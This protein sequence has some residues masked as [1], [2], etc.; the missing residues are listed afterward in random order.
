MPIF[1]TPITTDDNNIHKLVAQNIPLLIVFYDNEID[2]PLSDAM[3][4]EAKKN[5]GDLLIAR[6]KASENPN[7]YR[8]YGEPPTPALV[9][10][11]DNGKVKSDADNIRPA[12]LRN[13]VKHLLNDAPLP[14]KQKDAA[15]DTKH[16]IHVTDETFRQQVLKSKKPVLVD[17]WAAWCGPCHQIAP[18][19]SDV[20]K[21]HGSKMKVA[22]LDIDANQRMARRYNVQSIPTM[23]VFEN[24]QEAARITGANPVALRK[25]VERF[26]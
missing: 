15:S 20:A 2:K 26:T 16:P 22:K 9:T 11:T 6:M 8:K 5:S 17:F 13:H 21:N 1:D 19:I 23:I 14:E 7:T 12:D 4:K 25:M 3:S 18:Y 24:G 10:L